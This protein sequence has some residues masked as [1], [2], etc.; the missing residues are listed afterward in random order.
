MLNVRV[1]LHR[2]ATGLWAAVLALPARDVTLLGYLTDAEARFAAEKVA[3]A[4]FGRAP[5]FMED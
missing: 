5:Y 1:Y 4:A 2:S 3:L